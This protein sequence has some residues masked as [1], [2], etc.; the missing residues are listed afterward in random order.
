[1]LSA[2]RRILPAVLLLTLLLAPAAARATTFGAEVDG[3][4]F[5]QAHGYWTDQ[6]AE[7]SLQAL[8][9]AGGTVG[10]AD[11]DWA[12]TESSAPVHGR[13]RYDWAYD[14]TLVSEMAQ[15]HL[16]WQP[17][18]EYTPGWARPHTADRVRNSTG[19]MVTTPLPPAD[20]RNFAA[21]ATAFTRRYGAGG[22]FW[23]SNPTLPQLLP[24]EHTFE[25]WNEPDEALSWG[26]DVNLQTY[27]AMYEVVRTAIH[28]VNPHAQ[29]VTGGVAWTRS[30]L[31][32]LLR[33]FERK[34]LDAVAFHPYSATPGG[35]LSQ[36]RFAIAQMNKYGRG[37]TPLLANEYGWTSRTH[38]WGST[39]PS[40]VDSYSFQT[41]V[42]LS[43]LHLADVLPFL[44]TDPA[45][46]LS[47]GTFGRALASIHSHR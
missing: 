35:V 24:R 5:N 2:V 8:S 41:L 46:G 16:R 12:R 6:Q 29:V 11:S 39:I 14:D 15:A 23:R 37:R 7:A 4:F 3:A 43:K 17:S 44:W 28:R 13:H 21:Y 34:P 36:A 19:R 20:N 22:S 10:R 9:A 32:R 40:H 30:S 42:G 47:D 1:M 25:V 18:L 31:P 33:A 26:P 45:W 38:T 27:A